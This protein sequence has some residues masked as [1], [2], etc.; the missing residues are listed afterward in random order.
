MVHPNVLRNAGVD[1]A[2]FSGYAFGMGVERLTM[3]RYG[4]DDLRAVLRERPAVPRAVRLRL[5]AMRVN[6]EWLR[7]WVELDGDAA[8]R[9]RRSDDAGLEVEAVEPLAGARSTSSWLR[10]ARA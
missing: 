2:E 6:I 5:A 4:V 9:G 1:P 3:L 10:G 8:A 7:D